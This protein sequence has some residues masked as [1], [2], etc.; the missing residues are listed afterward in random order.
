MPHDDETLRII[1][2][3]PNRINRL[4]DRFA[5][6]LLAGPKSKPILIDFINDALLLESEDRIVDLTVVSGELAPDFVRMKLSVLDVSATLADKRTVDVE[7]QV[8]NYRDFEKRAPY[9]WAARH[10][11]KLTAG[12]A[13][14]EI[15]PTITICLLA[16]NLLKEEEEYRNS[17]S[18]RNDKSGNRLCEDMQIIYLELPKFLRSLGPE[19][20]RTGLERW[21]LY[22][23]NE[24]GKRM[25]LVMEEDPI[26]TMAKE[27]ESSY[28][29]DEKEKELYYQHQRLLLDA[30]SAEHTYEYLLAQAEEKAAQAE[31]K[32]K[33]EMARNLL[34]TGM[35]AGQIAQASDLP[36]EEIEQLRG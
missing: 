31:R 17:Y 14:V 6:Y 5:K 11:K 36:V 28:W 29:A 18:I 13:F 19:H 4:N 20:P 10:S 8:V 24:E 27:M 22:F 34:K 33:R 1:D 9:Y 25:S 26:L 21:L 12:M 7:L 16:F 15:K 2:V 30:Y 32:G 3:G 35:S 23:C